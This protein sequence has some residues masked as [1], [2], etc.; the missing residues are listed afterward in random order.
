M[1]IVERFNNN[2]K[3]T[4]AKDEIIDEITDD[5]EATRA[6]ANIKSDL[7]RLDSLSIS[8]AKES[9]RNIKDIFDE[10]YNWYRQHV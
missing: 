10:L 5:T 1:R 4:C 3:R 8:S 6:I 7:M 2:N 9:M